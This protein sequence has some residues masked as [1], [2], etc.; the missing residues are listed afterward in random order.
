MLPPLVMPSM[1]VESSLFIDEVLVKDS[2]LF[3]SLAL[4]IWDEIPYSLSQ[5]DILALWRIASMK[6]T[7]IVGIPAFIDSHF[8]QMSDHESLTF[9]HIKQSV[10]IDISHSLNCTSGELGFVH[11]WFEQNHSQVIPGS[12]LVKVESKDQKRP[13]FLVELDGKVY[14]VECKLTFSD[15]GKKQL[16]NYIRLWG[17]SHG[18]AVAIRFTSRQSKLITQINC[19]SL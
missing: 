3:C 12:K 6:S 19:P 2:E 11:R 7:R 14:P 5:W 15:K 18:Y 10:M 9:A 17:S 16:L 13:D 1:N 8:S 4:D